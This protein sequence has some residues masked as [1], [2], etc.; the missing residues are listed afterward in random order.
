[1]SER[2][3]ELRTG[4]EHARL[5]PCPKCHAEVDRAATMCEF[6]GA[7]LAS[8]GRRQPFTLEGVVCFYCGDH[9][10]W[11]MLGD[12]CAGCGRLFATTCPRCGE[13]VPLRA[14][15][16]HKC[17]LSVE[18][19]DVE[20]A[21]ATVKRARERRQEERSLWLLCWWAVVAGLLLI[22]F[23]WFFGRRHTEVRRPAILAGVFCTATAGAAMGIAALG[24]RSRSE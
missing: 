19:F 20:R 21:R 4:K 6:C 8:G 24:A 23:G 16:C 11:S 3:Y 12:R 13:G 2:D 18:N 1:M 15:H 9:N 7:L 22:L 10:R 17:G 14:R 5:R